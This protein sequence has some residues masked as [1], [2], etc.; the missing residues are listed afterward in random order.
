MSKPT[1][2]QVPMEGEGK[3]AGLSTNEQVARLTEE[4]NQM[5]QRFS[6]LEGLGYGLPNSPKQGTSQ[7][8]MAGSE[9]E[10]EGR[11]V[12]LES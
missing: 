1:N 11:G 6:R 10:A 12:R 5:R 2:E 4:L 9:G 7:V 8:A 3:Q